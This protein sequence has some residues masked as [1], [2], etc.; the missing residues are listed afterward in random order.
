MTLFQPGNYKPINLNNHHGRYRQN[1]R[2][3]CGFFNKSGHHKGVYHAFAT[4]D[5]PGYINAMAPNIEWNEA[6]DFPQA[7]GNP[8]L[9]PEAVVQ[10]VMGRIGAGW[11]Y[12]TITDRCVM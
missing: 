8:Y 3:K 7:D 1:R 4:D 10:G 12:R 11:E 5:F 9:G 6:G 2:P